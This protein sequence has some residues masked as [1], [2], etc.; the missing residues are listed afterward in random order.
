ME[1]TD[2]TAAARLALD[3][4]AWLTT[5]DA[6]GRPRT[7]PVWFLWDG[8][9]VLVYSMSGTARTR[10]LQANP[11]VSLHLEGNHRAGG[12]DV[13]ILEGTAGVDE[14][15]PTADRNDAYLEKYRLRMEVN[16]WT[17]EW[18]AEHYPVPIRMTIER[19]RA[20]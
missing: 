19:V 13:V 16:G 3:P 17:P 6:G 18:F 2:R 14:A 15:A 8:E 20:W 10:N 1:I 4:I 9:T 12:G 11:R 5:V 7:S